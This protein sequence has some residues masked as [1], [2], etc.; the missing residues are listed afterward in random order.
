MGARRYKVDRSEPAHLLTQRA[1]L[2]LLLGVLVG[3]GT[4]VLTA[5]AKSPPEGGL[6]GGAAAAAAVIFFDRVIAK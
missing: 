1:A 2:I 4:A 6:A 5:I 3:L